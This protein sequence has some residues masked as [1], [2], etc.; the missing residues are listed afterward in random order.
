MII[1]T[2]FFDEV[3][4]DDNNII[5][6]EE[7]LPGLEDLHDFIILDI[8][9]NEDI[10]CLQSIEKKE[11]CMLVIVPWNYVQDYEIDLPE[12]DLDGLGIKSPEDTGVFNV[13]SVRDKVITANLVAPIVININ[14][15]KGKQIILSNTK[16]NVRHELKC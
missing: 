9:D 2:K 7:G 1:M 14:D 4:I 6:F 13:I 15:K 12:E 3:E 5:H 8:E 10:K 16:Y 11:V